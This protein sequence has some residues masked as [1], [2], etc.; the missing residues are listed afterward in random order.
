V[1]PRDLERAVEGAGYGV[2]REDQT[3]RSL[4]ID[5]NVEVGSSS[6]CVPYLASALS[7]GSTAL[8]SLWGA[9]SASAP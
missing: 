1:E 7:R 8:R 6:S 2:I 9:I 5:M 3:M 4:R